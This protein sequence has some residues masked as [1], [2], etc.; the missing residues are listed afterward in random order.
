MSNPLITKAT[1]LFISL[2]LIVFCKGCTPP[3]NYFPP[4]VSFPAEGGVC[5]LECP[6]YINVFMVD[7]VLTSEMTN[8][9]VLRVDVHGCP[10]IVAYKWLTVECTA[11]C[12]SFKAE[13][14]DLKED[15]SIVVWI[16]NHE[17]SEP[18]RIRQERKN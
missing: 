2:L 10:D 1:R 18:I 14:N 16:S 6:E 15:R 17:T 3:M 9:M 4:S 5:K 8:E 11:N 12:V 7:S 13:P